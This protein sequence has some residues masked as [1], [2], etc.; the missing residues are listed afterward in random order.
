M[1]GSSLHQKC[2]TKM[3]SLIPLPN[4][5]AAYYAGEVILE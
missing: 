1:C 3:E 4:G 2:W 5:D